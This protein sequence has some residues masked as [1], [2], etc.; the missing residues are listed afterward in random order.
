MVIWQ[1]MSRTPISLDISSSSL[2]LAT[3][4]FF[5]ERFII[6]VAMAVMPGS[7]P[8][9][10]GMGMGMAGLA[11]GATRSLSILPFFRICSP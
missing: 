11:M 3:L 1:P 6:M 8:R 9:M 2:S 5:I 10:L 4:A 7:M